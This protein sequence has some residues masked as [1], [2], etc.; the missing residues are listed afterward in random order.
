MSLLHLVLLLFFPPSQLVVWPHQRCKSLN[1]FSL[2]GGFHT[3]LIGSKEK[4]RRKKRADNFK[5]LVFQTLW[6][7]ACHTLLI[8]LGEWKLDKPCLTR[9]HNQE[10]SVAK[11]SC[12]KNK[13]KNSTEAFFPSFYNF[14][15]GAKKVDGSLLWQDVRKECR[16]RLKWT[17]FIT[18]HIEPY[19]SFIKA[20]VMCCFMSIWIQIWCESHI[21]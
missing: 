7:F 17:E 6:P 15:C 21:D 11:D 16:Q 14:I 3:L 12:K 18:S 9:G 2:G 5:H 1:R 8:K 13:K 19:I 4:R 10:A 20:M